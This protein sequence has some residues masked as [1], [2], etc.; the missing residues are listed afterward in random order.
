VTEY[1]FDSQR[2]GKENILNFF[3]SEIYQFWYSKKI[4]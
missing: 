1:L 2:L 3:L 4:N